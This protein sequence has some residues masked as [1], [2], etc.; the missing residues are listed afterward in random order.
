[1]QQPTQNYFQLFG[2]AES[3]VVDL[4]ALAD[5]YRQ[6]QSENHP[7]RFANADE[8]ERIKAVQFTSL[9]NQAYDT[10]KQPMKRAGYLLQLRG[11][12]PEKVSQADLGMELLMEQMQLREALEEL[13]GDESALPELEMLKKQASEKMRQR[14]DEF[15]SLIAAEDID[16]ARRL[17]HEM[18]FMHKLI[19][20]IELGE[21]QRLGY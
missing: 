2:I 3:F 5:R 19:K 17:F 20:E 13:P 10:L 11:V 14:E 21:E 16:S 12:D 9:V 18:Q 8:S 7:D 6:L 4:P 1:M 15:S